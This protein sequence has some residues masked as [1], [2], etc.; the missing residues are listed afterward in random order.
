[1]NIIVGYLFTYAYIF[2]VLMLV[3]V[4]KKG[5]ANREELTRKIVH[6]SVSFSWIIMY[7]YF[8]SSIHLII[9]PLTFVLLNYMAYKKDIFSMERKEGVSFGT[10]YY[11]I[12][13][14]ILS[15]IS[16]YNPDFLPFYGIGLFCMSLGDGFAPI[17]ASKVCLMT[18]YIKGNRKSLAGSMTVFIA[19]FFVIY[20][21]SFLLQLPIHVTD[22]MFVSL[23][24]MILELIGV[25]GLD[26]LLLPV[27]IALLAYGC[28]WI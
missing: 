20:T 18:F 16:I 24:G 22:I 10:V 21:F 2:T 27:G 12:S 23:S 4:M 13:M 7:Y 25:R 5:H 14:V 6:I 19:C 1:M 9:P 28:I 3:H 8:G 11:P 26:N 15:G 17:V